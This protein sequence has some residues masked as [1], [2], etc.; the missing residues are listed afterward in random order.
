MKVDK[1]KRRLEEE[2]EL[3]GNRESIN[4]RLRAETEA[5]RTRSELALKAM[6][7]WDLLRRNL[8]EHLEDLYCWREVLSPYLYIF[9]SFS[10]TLPNINTPPCFQF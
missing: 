4:A 3:R 5:L 7:G 9:S 6:G 8:Q 1:L 2:S 10:L